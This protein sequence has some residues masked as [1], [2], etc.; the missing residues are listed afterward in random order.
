MCL[1]L[2]TTVLTSYRWHR[3][4]RH[5]TAARHAT[6]V[7][8]SVLLWFATAPSHVKTVTVLKEQAC[9]NWCKSTLANALTFIFQAPSHLEYVLSTACC[10]AGNV[11]AWLWV[12][13]DCTSLFWLVPTGGAAPQKCFTFC[14]CMSSGCGV[15]P[16]S[17]AAFTGK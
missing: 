11:T 14:C 17:V 15:L 10:H 16:V 7:M 4:W 2:T 8:T 1:D 3:H 12:W 13:S 5:A 9:G 6:G